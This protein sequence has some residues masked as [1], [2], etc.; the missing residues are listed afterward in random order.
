[1]YN[2]RNN[3]AGDYTLTTNISLTSYDDWEPIGSLEAPFTGKINGGG[4]KIVGLKIDRSAEEYVGLF[5]VVIGGEI[6]N[7]FLENVDINGDLSVGGI[8]GSVENGTIT[9]CYISGFI[10]ARFSAGGIAGSIYNSTIANCDSEGIIYADSF[11]GGTADGYSFSG[12]IAG[13]VWNTIIRDCFSVEQKIGSDFFSGGIVG[14]MGDRST[15]TNCYSSSDISSSAYGESE[16]YSGGIAGYVLDGSITN[17]GALNNEIYNNY[18]AA[19][20]AVFP[21]FSTG[22]SYNNFALDVMV[23]SGYAKF[24]NSNKMQHGSSKMYGELMAQSTYADA[25]N[26]DGLGGLG[27]K[28][29]DSDNAPWV[30]TGV[31]YPML[32][33]IWI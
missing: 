20:I 2:I 13:A 17:C 7:L 24:E 3:L 4:Y 16:S 28:F 29:G 18:Y 8:A 31:Y 14:F 26:G 25:V 9:N 1:M 23:A 11:S 12:G 6:T 5:G 19:R 22:L 10:R 21:T 32:Y 27:W 15:I 33:W 30:M